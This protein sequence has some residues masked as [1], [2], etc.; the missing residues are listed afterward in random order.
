MLEFCLSKRK[1]QNGGE[2]RIFMFGQER[3][4]KSKVTAGVENVLAGPGF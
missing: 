1:Q 2:S 3:A 4:E